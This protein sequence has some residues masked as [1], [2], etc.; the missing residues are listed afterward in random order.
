MVDDRSV[1]T[2]LVRNQCSALPTYSTKVRHGA[3]GF[4][5]VVRGAAVEVD[6]LNEVG[7]RRQP[8]GSIA[9]LTGRVC[10]AS[11]AL[12]CLLSKS[13]MAWHNETRTVK[14]DA[15]GAGTGRKER[16][17]EKEEDGLIQRFKSAAVVGRYPGARGR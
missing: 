11:T 8:L 14:G 9:R 12:L 7:R 17:K 1:A 2:P 15:G 4:V 13:V 16:K 3:Q 5:Q 10:L 6:G